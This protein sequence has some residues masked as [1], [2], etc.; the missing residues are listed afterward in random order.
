MIDSRRQALKLN[1][2]LY[3]ED[4]KIIFGYKN[5]LQFRRI[6][7]FLGKDVLHKSQI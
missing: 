6:S 5:C 4:N 7:E 1:D 2:R 3:D